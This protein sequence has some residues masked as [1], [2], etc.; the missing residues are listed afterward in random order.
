MNFF[1]RLFGTKEVTPAATQ[2]EPVQA[3]VINSPSEKRPDP[4]EKV[5]KEDQ[6]PTLRRGPYI[7]VPTDMHKVGY[8]IDEIYSFINRDYF[9]IG[10]D[11][12]IVNPSK[13]YSETRQSII[14]N[15]LKTMFLQVT[16]TYNEM[17]GNI[18]QKIEDAE[19]NMLCSV[20]NRLRRTLST[21]KEHV[22]TIKQM[23][24]WLDSDDPKMTR[25]LASYR[26][27]FTKGFIVACGGDLNMGTA[28]T[29]P[30]SSM[31]ETNLSI[32]SKT[33]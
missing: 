20:A 23:E 15:E 33:A 6:G 5:Q 22:D 7:G 1:E 3:P 30:T 18:E 16:H 8:P 12:A 14:R 17:I 32:N 27:G 19:A 10:Y 11:D 2:N 29:Y 21:Y 25:M 24:E 9:R 4:E 28:E 26:M 31:D 13:E